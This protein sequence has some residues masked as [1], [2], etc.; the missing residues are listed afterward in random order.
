MK[1]LNK[2]VWRA[3]H[4]ASGICDGGTCASLSAAQAAA[5]NAVKTI[6]TRG[7]VV[8]VKSPR[9]TTWWLVPKERTSGTKWERRP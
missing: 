9:G 1:N 6:G 2:Y 5:E 3:S 8:T 7:T 4:R